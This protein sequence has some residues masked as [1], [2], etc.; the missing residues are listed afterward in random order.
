MTKKTEKERISELEVLGIALGLNQ[1]GMNLLKIEFYQARYLA[2]Y[3]GELV[4]YR[5][6]IRDQGGSENVPL[7]VSLDLIPSI[8]EF[9][10]SR[11]ID[12]F[13]YHILKEFPDVVFNVL[14]FKEDE[15]DGYFYIIEHSIYKEPKKQ[16]QLELLIMY[17]MEKVFYSENNY[18]VECHSGFDYLKV[19]NGHN[20][21]NNFPTIDYTKYLEVYREK[22]EQDY[23]HYNIS[24]N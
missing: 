17:L 3:E 12:T 7:K 9:D 18:S 4:G 6:G 13:K 20:F 24:L 14:H 22:Q 2:Y 23:K 8:D 10:N 21:P 11:S 15:H 16:E 1:E 19:K 5:K